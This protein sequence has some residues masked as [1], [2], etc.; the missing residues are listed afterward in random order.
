H[1]LLR[2]KPKG[3]WN[4]N[5]GSSANEHNSVRPE[6]HLCE[7]SMLS[8]VE[9]IS[10]TAEEDTP[11]KESKSVATVS[12]GP[13]PEAPTPIASSSI[14]SPDSSNVH[15]EEC[16]EDCSKGLWLPGTLIGPKQVGCMV[17]LESFAFFFLGISPCENVSNAT[18]VVRT[19]VQNNPKSQQLVTNTN[20]ME[21]ILTNFTSDDDVIV[22]TKALGAISCTLFQISLVVERTALAYRVPTAVR[23]ARKAVGTGIGDVTVPSLDAEASNV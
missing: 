7:N 2:K 23:S 12:Q 9:P 15:D 20:G 17:E 4:L 22:Q 13:P 14:S 1:Q 6:L 3:F 18:E 5:E 10:S 19:I 8:M 11:K 21:P 16:E